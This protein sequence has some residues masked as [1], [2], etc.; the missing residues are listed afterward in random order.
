MVK[1]L[2]SILPGL[3][4]YSFS[5]MTGE[6]IYVCSLNGIRTRSSDNPIYRLAVDATFW[7]QKYNTGGTRIL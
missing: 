5:S 2:N 6:N 1:S 7:Y 4:K 3:F